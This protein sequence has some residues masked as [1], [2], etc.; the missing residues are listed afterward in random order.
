MARTR[1]PADGNGSTDVA[2][3]PESILPLTKRS[4]RGVRPVLTRPPDLAR[5]PGGDHRDAAFPAG[6]PRSRRKGIPER[7]QRR[8][9]APTALT[10]LRRTL[11]SASDRP[12][13]RP[14]NARRTAWRDARD[15]FRDDGA[16]LPLT[17]AA[18]IGRRRNNAARRANAEEP[19]PSYATPSP[20]AAPTRA[21]E[22][23]AR[24]LCAS[25]KKQ[26]ARRPAAR[27]AARA[28]PSVAPTLGA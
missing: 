28:T 4:T 9:A 18:A 2:R 12:D 11:R 22:P 14:V 17:I 8:Q 26:P 15:I 3:V 21:P 6:S 19:S 13:L 20:Y 25:T 5:R 24:M 10:H 7:G 23:R 16:S 1:C 27:A